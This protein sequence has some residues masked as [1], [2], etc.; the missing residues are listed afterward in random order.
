MPQHRDLLI[1]V[2]FTDQLTGRKFAAHAS[3]TVNPPTT[4]PTP[5]GGA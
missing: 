4:Q 5:A 1:N 3:V 2:T